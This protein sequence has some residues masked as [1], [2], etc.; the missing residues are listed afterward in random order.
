[1]SCNE[2]QRETETTEKPFTGPCAPPA[3]AGGCCGADQ[4]EQQA[5]PWAATLARCGCGPTEAK[6]AASPP[7]TL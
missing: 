6:T 1:M 2:P 4:S 3:G 7:E 5:P